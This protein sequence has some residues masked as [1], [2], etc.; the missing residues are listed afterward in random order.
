MVAGMAAVGVAVEAGAAVGVTITPVR[1][2]VVPLDM[3]A[4]STDVFPNITA[5]LTDLASVI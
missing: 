1:M 5:L 2:P 4:L 3:S